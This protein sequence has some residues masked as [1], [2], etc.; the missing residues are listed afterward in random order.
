[1][2]ILCSRFEEGIKN[3]DI[4]FKKKFKSNM[5]VAILPWAFPKEI[6]SE[7]LLEDYFKKGTKRYNRYVDNLKDLGIK[8]SNIKVLDCYNKDIKMLKKIIN[9]SDIVIMPGGNPEMLYEK[10]IKTGCNECLN[11]K[12]K[13]IIGE[14][15]GA[16]VLFD[17]YFITKENNYYEK[18]DYYKGINIIKNDFYIDVHTLDDESY[19]N[20]L[21][22]VLKNKKKT[23]YAIHEDGFL[24][25][26]DNI[27]IYGIVDVIN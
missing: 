25:L 13:I 16:L 7:L 15:A 12:K 24:V 6:N 9:D 27:K 11:D 8:E 23:I 19:Q 1:M 21:K 3:V 4:N 10:L 22:D 2:Y 20:E 18:L 14:S 5:T 17:S 26:D